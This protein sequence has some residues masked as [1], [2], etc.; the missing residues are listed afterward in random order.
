[1]YIDS[2]RVTGINNEEYEYLVKF[3][4]EK[5]GMEYKKRRPDPPFLLGDDSLI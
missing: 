1:V 3:R 2:Y 5:L 4:I